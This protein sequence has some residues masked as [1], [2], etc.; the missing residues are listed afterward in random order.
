MVPQ[1]PFSIDYVPRQSLPNISVYPVLATPSKD[2]MGPPYLGSTPL[3][4]VIPRHL[5]RRL[6][7]GVRNTHDRVVFVSSY[8]YPYSF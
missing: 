6:E 2:L 1:F 8:V 4:V 5:S 3:N 7:P